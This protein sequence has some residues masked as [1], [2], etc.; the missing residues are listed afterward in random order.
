MNHEGTKTTKAQEV[1]EIEEPGVLTRAAKA[2]ADDLS[3]EIIASAIEVHRLLGPGLL[4]SAY[5]TC[6]AKELEIRGVEHNRQVMLPLIYKG[7]EL[8]APYRVDLLVESLVIVELKSVEAIEPIHE[9]QLLTYLRLSRR[10]MGL[11]INF[12]TDV[13]RHGLRRMLNG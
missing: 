12:N 4:E 13:V 6:L 1:W 2:R 8:Q 7:V 3:G 5:E 9:A 10:W 11:L